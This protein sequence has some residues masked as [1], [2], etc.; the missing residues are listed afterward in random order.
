MGSLPYLPIA[1]R[2]KGLEARLLAAELK[3]GLQDL[4]RT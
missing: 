3:L 1:C 2:L 4:P